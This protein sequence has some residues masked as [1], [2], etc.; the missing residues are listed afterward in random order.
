MY[1]S[2]LESV[3]CALGELCTFSV[4][5]PPFLPHLPP[6][7]IS[8]P[9]PSPSPH[10]LPPFPISLPSPSPSLPLP[11]PSPSPPHLPPLPIPSPSPSLPH[12]PPRLSGVQE[13]YSS[14]QEVISRSSADLKCLKSDEFATVSKEGLDFLR[15][16]H[17][18]KWCWAAG[19]RM[20]LVG[21][22]VSE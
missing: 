15:S 19:K 5:T 8:L 18:W 6:F 9:S 11:S 14:Q 12:L 2:H 16:L 22:G 20:M 21:L 17:S 1:A 10:H 13:L 4:Y 3:C 7:P